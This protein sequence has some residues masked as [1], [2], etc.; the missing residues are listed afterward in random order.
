MYETSKE[1]KW[2]QTIHTHGNAVSGHQISYTFYDSSYW[3]LL[4]QLNSLTEVPALSLQVFTFNTKA[5]QQEK[6]I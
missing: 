4:V 5:S 1:N 6:I 2:L 3:F